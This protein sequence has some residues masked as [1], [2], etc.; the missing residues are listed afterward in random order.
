[1]IFQFPLR[2]LERNMKPVENRIFEVGGGVNG[3]TGIETQNQDIDISQDILDVI[4]K[5]ESNNNPGIINKNDN[6]QWSCG[7][8]QIS[9]K[10]QLQAYYKELKSLNTQKV[11]DLLTPALHEK[12]SK[13]KNK[14]R[15]SW[16]RYKIKN[17]DS[18]SVIADKFHTSTKLIKR[19][20]NIDG[21]Q[22]RAGKHLLIPVAT[23]SLDHYIFSQNQRLVK[24]QSR[25][26]AGAKTIHT[27]KSG[28][29]LWDLGQAYHV[30]SRNLAKWN[31]MAPRDTLKLGQKLV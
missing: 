22:I 2:R 27:V 26:H 16:Q 10:Y 6:G 9:Q 30:S 7:L 19:L 23:A 5:N 14:D 11:N 12:L 21:S 1:M 13:L 28:D 31:G 20:N 24:K 25:Q 18:L 4:A 17:G 29:T 15:L 3:S 8:Y